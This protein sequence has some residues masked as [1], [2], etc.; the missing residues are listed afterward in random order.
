MNREVRLKYAYLA[1]L[2]SVILPTTHTPHISQDYSEKI[3][4]LDAFLCILEGG[5]CLTC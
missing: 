4:D 2:S 3:K 1:L 5:F